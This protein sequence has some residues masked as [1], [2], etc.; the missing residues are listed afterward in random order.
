MQEKNKTK[1][2]WINQTDYEKIIKSI[3]NS[4]PRWKKELCNNE[5]IISIHSKK[6]NY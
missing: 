6:L 4:W 5:L 1:T 2:K 3:D